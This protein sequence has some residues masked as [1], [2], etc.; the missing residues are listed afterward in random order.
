MTI[1]TYPL[2]NRKCNKIGWD[3]FLHFSLGPNRQPESCVIS[4][5]KQTPDILASKIA[6]INK[7]TDT[8]KCIAL[9][10]ATIP[11]KYNWLRTHIILEL[12]N[13]LSRPPYYF[14]LTYGFDIL[15][16]DTP[17]LVF[18][19][20]LQLSLFFVLLIRSAIGYLSNSN[21]KV[22]VFKDSI[23]K[24]NALVIVNMQNT[25]NENVTTKE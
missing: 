10:R 4:Y 21:L 22:F 7:C 23:G 20:C 8:L 24:S 5:T 17:K 3:S 16:Y 18:Y 25:F 9:H 14:L 15:T 11:T 19:V 1:H 6:K 13:Q 12:C 2:S